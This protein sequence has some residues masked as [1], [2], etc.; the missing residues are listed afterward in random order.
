MMFGRPADVAKFIA[1]TA[2]FAL[3]PARCALGTAVAFDRLV[4]DEFPKPC[5]NTPRRF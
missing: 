5:F 2:C 4:A 1:H 3:P